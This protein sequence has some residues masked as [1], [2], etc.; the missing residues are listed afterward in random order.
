MLVPNETFEAM[1]KYTG[2]F[3]QPSSAAMCRFTHWT[4]NAKVCL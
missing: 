1:H 3:C 4:F 2:S